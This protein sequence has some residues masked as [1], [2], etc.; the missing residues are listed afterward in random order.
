MN[1]DFAVFVKKHLT[2]QQIDYTIGIENSFLFNYKKKIIYFLVEIVVM[3]YAR[4]VLRI[5]ALYQKE[6]G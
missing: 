6:T 4:N 3:V 5:N 2:V 1:A